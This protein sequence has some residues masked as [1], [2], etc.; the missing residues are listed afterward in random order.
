[1]ITGA[2]APVALHIARLLDAAGHHIVMAD[3]LRWP[4]GAASNACKTYVR[5]PAANGDRAL[6]AS[7][8]GKAV[9]AHRI[10]AVIPTCEEVFHL[11]RIWSETAIAAHLFAPDLAM[12]R[13][14]HN[15]FSFIG[16]ASSLGL[17][18]P[19][20]LLLQ[21]KSDIAELAAPSNQL[22]FKPVWS[23]FATRVQVRPKRVT[24]AP[25]KEDPWVAQEFV[26]GQEICAYVIGFQ[27][28]LVALSAYRP[29]YRAGRGAGIA[30]VADAD[31]KIAN[32]V[33]RFVEGTGWH[34]QVSFD[35]IRQADG[36][37]FAIECNPR[38]TSGVHLFR[39]SNAFA[40]SILHGKPAS[41]DVAGPL[42]VKA[43]VA[44]YGMRQR[45]VAVWKDL[46]R[47]TDVMMWPGDP[48]PA[49]QQIV[50][51]GEFAARALSHRVSLTEATTYDIAWRGD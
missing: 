18:V 8:I 48:R 38:A 7:A 23:R 22:V 4:V 49:W 40:Q 36:T 37:L 10:D 28:K 5:L 33:R 17:D 1:M 41:P 46:A 47:M 12:L 35:F 2:R 13:D 20:T 19:R 26:P 45:P 39:R 6:Y 34:G 9:T 3:S 24:C 30:F 25:T 44:I 29:T 42:G 43:A 21:S 31:P 16:L 11:A 15:K 27:G 51:A 14:A 32:Y 50:T